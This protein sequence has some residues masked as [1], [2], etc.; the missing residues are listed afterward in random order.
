LRSPKRLRDALAVVPPD[1]RL[2]RPAYDRRCSE[3]API[4]LPIG[5]ASGIESVKA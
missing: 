2:A 3:A 4:S 5:V 1:A